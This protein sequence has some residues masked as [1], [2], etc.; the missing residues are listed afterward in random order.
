VLSLSSVFDSINED[1]RQRILNSAIEEFATYGYEMAS[2]NRIVEKAGISKGMLFHYFKNKKGLFFYLLDYS[3]PI[4]VKEFKNYAD[5]S[6][7]DIFERLKNWQ[8]AKFKA[9]ENYP[10]SFEFI[11]K[12][13]FNSPNELKEELMERYKDVEKKSYE[14]LF[15][16]IDC[17]K[18]KPDINIQKALEVLSWTL[19]GYGNRYMEENTDQNGN[20]I[21]D[22]DKLLREMDEYINI[23]KLGFYR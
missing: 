23:L 12:A 9:F 18:F 19:E 7:K 2:T 14:M 16:G 13:F 10:Y 17:S 20:T 15:E 5:K 6:P 8:I 3:I 22:N 21:I 4:L 11:K 1:K